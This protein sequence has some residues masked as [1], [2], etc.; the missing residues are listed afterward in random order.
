MPA[1][2]LPLPVSCCVSSGKSLPPPGPP[3]RCLGH[4]AHCGL[5]GLMRPQTPRTLPFTLSCP[6]SCQLSICRRKA[7]LICVTT[8][9]LQTPCSGAGDQVPEHAF[10]NLQNILNMPVQIRAPVAFLASSRDSPPPF[11][12]SSYTNL[13][14]EPSSFLSHCLHPDCSLCLEHSSPALSLTDFHSAFYLS[15]S[16]TASGQPPPSP[17]PQRG[18]HITHAYPHL[19]SPS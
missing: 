11:L 5:C 15:S 17:P 6:E 2:S 8:L 1:G 13:P 19:H 4:G 10:Q 14:R 3:C 18:S 7:N 12:S 9:L 16:R